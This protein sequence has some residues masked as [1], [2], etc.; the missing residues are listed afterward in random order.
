MIRKR[1]MLLNKTKMIFCF[2]GIVIYPF[3]YG[4]FIQ[5]PLSTL[6]N[7]VDGI[8]QETIFVVIFVIPLKIMF[9]YYIRYYEANSEDV[10][11]KRVQIKGIEQHEKL[12][13]KKFKNSHK[14]DLL[15]GRWFMVVIILIVVL[16]VFFICDGDYRPILKLKLQSFFLL[17]GVIFLVVSILHE[18]RYL[19]IVLS[20]RLVVRSFTTQEILFSEMLNFKVVHSNGMATFVVTLKSGKKIELSYSSLTDSET[21][22]AIMKSKVTDMSN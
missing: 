12:V 14:K 2:A 18:M 1:L 15:L 13:I 3:I 22:L 8:L 16:S 9:V 5:L 20:D 21:L 10:W 4:Y 17:L 11:R 6:I 19:I 7:G